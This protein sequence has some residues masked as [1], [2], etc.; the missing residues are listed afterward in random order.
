M[1]IKKGFE[2]VHAFL[3]A[4]KSKKVSTIL[5]DLVALMSAKSAGGSDIGKTFLKTAEGTTYAVYCYYHKRWELTSVAEF[6][7]KANTATGLN[8]MCKEGVSMW[9]KQQRAFK[10]SKDSLLMSMAEGI[11]VGVDLNES[12][13][14][15]EEIRK[16]IEVRDDEHGYDTAEEAKLAYE[17][18]LI[19][20]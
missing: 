19:A 16:Q 6:G 9:S 13:S 7:A 1:T 12:L 10:K 3:E 2:E 14:Q 4:N 8:T 11:L 20:E 5:A 15:L 17:S 18:T